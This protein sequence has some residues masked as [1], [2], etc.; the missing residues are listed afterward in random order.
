MIDEASR[1]LSNKETVDEIAGREAGPHRTKRFEVCHESGA[2]LCGEGPE[3][4]VFDDVQSEVPAF[5]TIERE[6]LAMYNVQAT[7][8]K[9]V[10]V[11]IHSV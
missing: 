10:A 2:K 3:R 9:E 8:N 4:F 11:L 1:Q 7:R 5:R 6:F